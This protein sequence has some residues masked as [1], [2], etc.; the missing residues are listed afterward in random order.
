MFLKNKSDTVT[1]LL[2]ILQRLP[3]AWHQESG[4][5]TSA[6]L[7]SHHIFY[8]LISS[9]TNILIDFY[10]QQITWN[11]WVST[12]SFILAFL[13]ELPF[14][15][16][17]FFNCLLCKTVFC[18]WVFSSKIM[19]YSLHSIIKVLDYTG[20]IKEGFPKDKTSKQISKTWVDTG[21]VYSW[22]NSDFQ[23]RYWRAAVCVILPSGL[24]DPT[25]TGI[26]T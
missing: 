11:I 15:L 4:S 24:Y 3:I 1:S 9:N 20:E 26:C 12:I 25:K 5:C 14:I 16:Q 17:T 13:G 22:G 21:Q 18:L 10:V 2:E 8:N 19:N 6:S 7:F 23:V